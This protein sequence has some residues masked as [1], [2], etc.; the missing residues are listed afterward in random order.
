[1]K[2]RVCNKNN[3]RYPDYGGRGIKIHDSWLNEYNQFERDILAICPTDYL[4]EDGADIAKNMSIER[5]D[6]N[7]NYEPGNCAVIPFKH[8]A[9]NTRR[10]VFV[11]IDG[12]KCHLEE[13]YRRLKI[14]SGS[15]ETLA[16]ALK[17][18]RDEALALYVFRHNIPHSIRRHKV[19]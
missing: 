17:I 18:P 10:S 11:L 19:I 16:Y 6:V 12:E 2:K 3:K 14:N 5:I 9:W 7:G 8:Q 1:M 13:A 15:I 4:N